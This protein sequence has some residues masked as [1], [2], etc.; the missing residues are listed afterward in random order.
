V[1]P[2]SAARSL[3]L[4]SLFD[5]IAIGLSLVARIVRCFSIFG[6]GGQSADPT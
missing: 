6:R 1:L 5:G 2:P 3:A 4:P